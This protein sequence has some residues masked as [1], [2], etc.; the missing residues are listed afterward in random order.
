MSIDEIIDG[1]LDREGGYV[2]HP[3]DKGGPTK[4]GIKLATLSS[5]RG[6]NSVVTSADVEK[7]NETEARNIYRK[8][9]VQ[10]P[11]FEALQSD[12]LRTIM[13]DC[14]VLHGP[15]RAIEMLQQALGDN[16]PDGI[17]GPVTLG[18][19]N[20]SD[21]SKLAIRL[22]AERAEK[23][24]RIISRDPTQA[25]FAHGWLRTRV[26]DFLRWIAA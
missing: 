14:G 19:A 18:L 7:L 8:L 24:G 17:L 16:N 13:V 6:P 21:E 5:W 22:L 1:I 26:S 15:K 23:F 9:Y 11:G 20:A 12:K 2:D 25:V 10:D 4:F 3:A